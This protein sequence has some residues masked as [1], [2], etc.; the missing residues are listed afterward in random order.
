M[1]VGVNE[2]VVSENQR[3][4]FLSPRESKEG[5]FKWQNWGGERFQENA[6]SHVGESMQVEKH[7]SPEDTRASHPTPVGPG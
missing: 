1:G 2:S 3:R 6:K 4:G 5:R 7:P